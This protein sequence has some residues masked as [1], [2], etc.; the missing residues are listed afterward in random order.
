VGTIYY[1]IRVIDALSDCADPN[2]NVVSVLVRPDATVTASIN[3]AE[4]CVGGSATLSA[5]LTGG[6]ALASL[7]WQTS[8]SSTGPWS[9]I[10]GATGTTYNPATGTAERGVLALYLADPAP[11]RR[12]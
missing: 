1:R 8:A 3:N 5:T 6:S 7:Q 2:S 12:S 11:H 4:I 10:S 9:D